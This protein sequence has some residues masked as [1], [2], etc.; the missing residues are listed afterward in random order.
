MA[1]TTPP[2]KSSAPTPRR[3][4]RRIF[5]DLAA[6]RSS[7][8]LDHRHRLTYQV[9]YDV[10]WFKTSH[11]WALKNLVGNWEFAPIYTYQ[12]GNWFTVQ[13]GLDSNLNGDSGGDR[14]FVNA[15]GNPNIG[16]GTTAL[17][18]SS[19]DTV[20]FL[21]NNPAAGYVTAPK[22]TLSTAGRNTERLNPTNDID[23]TFAKIDRRRHRV[24]VRLQFSG[25]F[26]NILNHPQYVGGNISDVAPSDSPARRF[27]TSPIPST[28]IF[29]VPQEAFSSNPRGITVSAKFTF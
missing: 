1:S 13:S 14:A 2:R 5:A 3:A 9:L 17:K 28:S 16:S 25:R 15:G 23:A 7:S 10:P 27:T 29:H 20:A 24:E 4:G 21:I 8:A 22:G 26:F 6:D 19:G 12:T 18:N 11:N